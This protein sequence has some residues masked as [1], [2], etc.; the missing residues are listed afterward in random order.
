MTHIIYFIAGMAILLIIIPWLWRYQIKPHVAKNDLQQWLQKQPDKHELKQLERLL[1]NL[2]HGVN[3]YAISHEN[4]Q[5]LALEE[6][7]FIYGEIEF[8]SFL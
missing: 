5:R 2:Y 1:T 4:R 7:A 6:D 3:A 8:L